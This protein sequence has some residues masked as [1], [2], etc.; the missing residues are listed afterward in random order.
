[1]S[2][3]LQD[4]LGWVAITKAVN[5]IKDGVPNP[6]PAWMFTVGAEDKVIGD[7]VKFNRTY[8]TRKTAR[9]VKY[10]APPRH[11]ELQ[12]EDLVE[13]KMISFG[14]ERQFRPY[15][16]QVLREYES[17]Q[18]GDMA[19][20]LVANNIKTLATM[21]G[22]SRIV[23]VAT[24]LNKGNIYVD[25]D[26]NLLPSSS[27]AA[28]TISQQIS[29]NNI[30]TIVAADSTNIF[31]ATGAGSWANNAT[32]IPLQLRRLKESAGQAH[33]YEPRIALYGK[34]IPSYIQQNNF[35]LDYMAR[36][37][38]LQGTNLKDNTIPDL[39]GFTWIPAWMASYTKDDGTKTSLWN[40][41]GITFMPDQS[42]AG[43][44]WSMFEGSNLVPRNLNLIASYESALNDL[45]MVW[46]SY[47]YGQLTHKPVSMCVVMGDTFLPA[48]KLPDT[49][50]IA[51]V[52]A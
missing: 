27:G 5:A 24:T 29:S 46:G 1:M 43:A 16:L 34:N 31:G 39:F 40:A 28:V 48:V 4:I 21:F 36:T 30:G 49:V 22:N 44:V 8:G 33:W 15:E 14:E 37:P 9:V 7:S 10:G 45:E 26:G 19:K 38:G 47:G 23:A 51:D 25:S 41:D 13:V 11:R 18:N 32:D 17:T 2:K 42:D 20:R 3:S 12:D 52:V 35:V 6:F 50:Y